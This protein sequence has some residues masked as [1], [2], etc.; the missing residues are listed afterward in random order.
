MTEQ[1]R[2]DV[3]TVR[4]LSWS[5]QELA[6]A[7]LGAVLVVGSPPRAACV[8]GKLGC[9]WVTDLDQVQGALDTLVVVGGG[10]RID[11]VKVWRLRYR[12]ELQL[13]AIASLWGSGAENSPIAVLD[14]DGKKEILVGPQYLPDIRCT[15][16]EFADEI[17][18]ALAQDGAGDVWA[19]ALEGFLSPLAGDALRTE[20]AAL[21]RN[22]L[23]AP[24]GRDPRWFAYSAQASS[25]QAR[26][27]VGLVHGIAHQLEAPLRARQAEAG[28]GHAALCAVFV[29]PVM[30]FN[31]Q[32]SLR[33]KTLAA[34]FDLD[35]DRLL[36]HLSRFHDPQRYDAALPELQSQWREILRDPSTRINSALVRPCAIDY[37]TAGA[38]P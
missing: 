16:P 36:L 28:W 15:F 13:V 14:Q 38:F 11:Q 32:S 23:L 4:P 37:F 9:S 29:F 24:C 12:P 10:R 8:A 7:N 26:S 34:E 3:S 33:F 6:Q 1:S 18:L 31:Y 22:L 30:C 21:I 2:C 35:A 19:H 20:L 17:P 27:S 25:C 5:P